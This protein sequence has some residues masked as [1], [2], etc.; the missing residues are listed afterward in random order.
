MR[1]CKVTYLAVLSKWHCI[2]SLQAVIRMSVALGSTRRVAACCTRSLATA[3]TSSDSSASAS[4]SR[5]KFSQKLKTGPTLDDFIAGDGPD[6]SDRIILGNSK[7]SVF[8]T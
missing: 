4:A 8:Q 6:S 5:S 7:A 2:Q 1:V 3:A